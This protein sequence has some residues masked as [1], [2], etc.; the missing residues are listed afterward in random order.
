MDYAAP[1]RWLVLATLASIASCAT[2]AK[3]QPGAADMKGAATGDLS[4]ARDL[5]HHADLAGP[6]DLE[7]QVVDLATQA[8]SDLAS[9][10]LRM[11]PQD[12]TTSQDLSIPQDLSV[13]KDL[14]DPQDLAVPADLTQPPPPPDLEDPCACTHKCLIVCQLGCCFEDIALKK[15]TPSLFC[16]NLGGD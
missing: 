12:L 3:P 5:G 4:G 1:V 7:G 14:S 11:N 8:P 15:C 13:P 9:A 10:D 2:S 16:L 6:H